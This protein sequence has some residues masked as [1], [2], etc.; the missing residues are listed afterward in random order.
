VEMWGLL[1]APTQAS[2]GP[3][4][5]RFRWSAARD[6]QKAAG[7]FAGEPERVLARA[8]GPGWAV[9]AVAGEVEDDDGEREPAAFAAALRRED[10]SWRLELDGI[11]FVGHAPHPLAELGND[12]PVLEVFAQS[13][14]RIARMVLWLGGEPVGARIT[15]PMP[16]TG[17]IAARAASP[18]PPGVHVL[19]VFA[20]TEDT[21]A[22]Q[23][24]PFEVER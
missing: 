5:D 12:E 17:A 10:G 15:R 1:S 18:L 7:R 13:S 3:S 21:A 11:F 4:L 24:W 6:L 22:A 16:F 8:L 23:A 14:A 9:A 20:A 19:T 2:L